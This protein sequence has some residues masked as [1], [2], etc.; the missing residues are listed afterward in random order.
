MKRHSAAVILDGAPQI[1]IGANFWSRT[2]GPLM[3]RSY[4][5]AVIDEEL[6]VMRENGMMLTRSFF[7][8]PDFMPTPDTIDETLVAKFGDFLDRHHARGMHSIPTFIVGHMSGQNWDPAWRG[9]RDLF[10]DVWF[11]GRQAWYVRELTAR[12]KDHPAVA[13]WLLTNEVPIYGDWRSRGVGTLDPAVVTAWAQILIDAVRAGGGTQPVSV[14]DGAW[15]VEV[16][17]QDHGFRVRDMTPLVDFLGPHVYGMETDQVR[18]HLRGAFVCELLSGRDRPVVMEEFG[19]TSDFTS[20]E[21]GAHY[22]RQQLHHT[23][24]AGATGWIAWNNTDFDDLYM[25][26]PYTH[27]PFELHFGLTDS[28][29]VAKPAA[30]EMRDFARLVERIDLARCSR[31]DSRI[32]MVVSSYL[33]NKYPFTSP[34][35]GP[36]IIANLGQA[37]VA[38]READLPVAVIRESDAVAWQPGSPADFKAGVA[39]GAIQYGRAQLTADDGRVQLESGQADPRA[40]GA[41][42][43]DDAALYLVPSTK[44]LTSPTWF[45]LRDLAEGGATVYCSYF[46]GVHTNQRGP[47]WPNLRELF[48]VQHQLRYGLVSRIDDDVL[49]MTF[50]QDFGGI[51]AGT[52]LRFG[53]AGNENSRCYLP[54]EPDGAE[55]V[56]RDAHGRPALLRNRIGTGAAVLCTYPIEHM[57][58]L[59][60]GVN[61]E[62]TWR[63]YA[64]L[65]AEAGVTPE[66]R[67]DSPDITC[68]EM[69]H[70]DG[71]RFVWLIN[72]ADSEQTATPILASG[73]LVDE[74]GVAVAEVTLPAF[75][76]QVLELR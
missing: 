71:R 42:L 16:T 6:D 63:L 4:D 24:L 33:D 20:D 15:G 14:G 32:A 31:P 5:C 53:V 22:Y 23:L 1:W 8:W 68:G 48:G 13:G 76:V 18:Q 54:V 9:G 66:V 12:F 2:G 73:S 56:A 70:E 59:T 75:G 19:L 46:V 17:G 55:V 45:Q 27:R 65:A 35:D 28:R 21:N 51:A 58:A 37:Y 11:V 7:Y 74:A 39:K 30:R 47:W 36:T 10:S 25:Q 41:G 26:A 43:P 62:D 44:H 69:V 60:A 34:L 67:V 72:L 61:P 52:V 29:G 49:E 3:W 64:A 40:L 38:A 50:E 57:A